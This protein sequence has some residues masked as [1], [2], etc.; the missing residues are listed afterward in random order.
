MRAIETPG[1]TQGHLCLWFEE[2]KILLSGDMVFAMGCGRPFEGS[3]KDLYESF[4]KLAFLPDD[5]QVY[6]GH[7]YT[8]TNARFANE[9]VPEN[10]AIQQRLA[11][12]KIA[13]SQGEITIP[14]NMGIERQT[15]PFLLAQSLEE[16]ESFRA[17][18]NQF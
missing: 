14:T 13:R 3:A 8:L 7:E 16:F 15:N 12:V 6:C 17:K 5:A 1:H 11:Q 10:A 9:I 18:R 2:S 4:Q